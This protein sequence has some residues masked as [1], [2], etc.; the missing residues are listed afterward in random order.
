MEYIKPEDK[1][2]DILTKNAPIAIHRKVADK[3]KN[4]KLHVYGNYK[5][6]CKKV[7]VKDKEVITSYNFRFAIMITV[8][9]LTSSNFSNLCK[10]KVLLLHNLLGR[11][12]R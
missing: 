6:I 12:P 7:D 3:L 9:I 10:N 1:D 11:L 5:E 4:G 8:A 2:S